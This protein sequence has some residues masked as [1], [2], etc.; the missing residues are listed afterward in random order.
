MLLIVDLF[1]QLLVITFTYFPCC[2][3]NANLKI[4]SFQFHYSLLPSFSTISTI[5]SKHTF[6][7]TNR[8]HI[9]YIVLCC[10]KTLFYGHVTFYFFFYFCSNETKIY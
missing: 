6:K 1:K 2:P 9:L 5:N 3:L 8:K 10:L 7:N 4:I